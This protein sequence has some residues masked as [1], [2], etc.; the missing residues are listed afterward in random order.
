VRGLRWRRPRPCRR[1][2]RR[3]RRDR[4]RGQGEGHGRDRERRRARRPGWRHGRAVRQPQQPQPAHARRE[5]AQ[6]LAVPAHLRHHHGRPVPA[7]EQHLVGGHPRHVARRHQGLARFAVAL[8]AVVHQDG[9][10]LAA[11]AGIGR[12]HRRRAGLLAEPFG[13]FVRRLGERDLD[14][15]RAHDDLLALRAVQLLQLGKR[16][17][18]QDEAHAGAA[19]RGH[20]RREVVD[21]AQVAELV[22]IAEDLARQHPAR[23]AVRHRDHLVEHLAEEA[24]R[25]RPQLLAHAPVEHQEERDRA[26]VPVGHLREGR[27]VATRRG[28]HARVGH[29][30]EAQG[31]LDE[32]GALQLLIAL[33]VGLEPL[34]RLAHIPGGAVA[35]RAHDR[36]AAQHQELADVRERRLAPLRGV[37]V[38]HDRRD[39]VLG[40]RI[41][42]G[43]AATLT[44]VGDPR[45][46]EHHRVERGFDVRERVVAR[47][48]RRR[49]EVDHDH[50]MGTRQGGVGPLGQLTLEVGGDDAAHPAQPPA[51][52]P[53]LG[54]VQHPRRQAT[55]EAHPRARALA[56]GA[57]RQ[58]LL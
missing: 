43:L 49:H 13:V 14:V 45:L 42:E 55:V 29:N 35:E 26:R 33:Q 32:D 6:P 7:Q 15:A 2:G 47:A 23:R 51:H 38:Q 12:E 17:H 54:P 25:E 48:R 4:R 31:Q 9:T 53:A 20:P 21:R 46:R 28:L 36:R 50:A 41:P 56:R 30:L 8:V 22:T 18:R 37:Q 57:P 58:T 40:R 52:Q 34:H 19:H 5:Q 27:L 11:H 16:L 24:R 39:E 44:R 10:A 3:L 1:W